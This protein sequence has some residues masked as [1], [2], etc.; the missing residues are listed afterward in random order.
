MAHLSDKADLGKNILR[1]SLLEHIAIIMTTD[2]KR[3]LSDR[4]F[5][6]VL[7]LIVA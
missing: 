1:V 3:E 4:F 7:L 5:F 2:W 6:P